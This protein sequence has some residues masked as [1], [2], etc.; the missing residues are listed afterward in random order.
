MRGSFS[1]IV[2]LLVL[3]MCM[4][5]SMICMTGPLGSLFGGL[6][7]LTKGAGNLVGGAASGAGKGVNTVG[8][9]VSGKAFKS[10]LKKAGPGDPAYEFIQSI[11]QNTCRA[12]RDSGWTSYDLGSNMSGDCKQKKYTAAN[13]A[14][15][16]K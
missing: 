3:S 11:K 15:I 1:G 2:L 4:S 7:S 14:K 5:S 9:V 16:L 13:C 6:G 12:C 10:N 8:S